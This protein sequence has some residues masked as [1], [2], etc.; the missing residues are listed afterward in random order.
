MKNGRK[1][2]DGLKYKDKFIDALIEDLTPDDPEPEPTPTQD[3]EEHDIEALEDKIMKH[4]DQ[5]IE[6][7]MSAFKLPEEPK[8]E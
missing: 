1:G 6:S 7:K 2:C 8:E 4:I 5:M 3:P